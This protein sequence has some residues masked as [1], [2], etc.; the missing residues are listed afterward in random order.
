MAIRI[1]E[2]APKITPRPDDSILA[3]LGI[4]KFKWVNEQSQERGITNRAGMFNWIV[5]KGGKAY[6]KKGDSVI[7]VFGANISS[8]QYI[9]TVVDGKWTDDLLDLSEISE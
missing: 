4:E 5:N 6:I 9:R 8:G 1:I 3:H 2:I 7:F